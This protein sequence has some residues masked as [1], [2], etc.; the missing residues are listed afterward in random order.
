[1]NHLTVFKKLGIEPLGNRRQAWDGVLPNGNRVLV[2]WRDQRTS[3]GRFHA[4]W[5]TKRQRGVGPIHRLDSLQ[6][7]VLREQPMFAL[8]A[9][10]V[11][12]KVS[13]RTVK[14]CDDRL[15]RVTEVAMGA[16][17]WFARVEALTCCDPPE[18]FS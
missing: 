6:N 15:L 3:D 5:R 4:L 2:L 18:V 9:D 1:V 8:L 10:A 13:P 7:F 11:D 17:H 14:R 16:T 12:P